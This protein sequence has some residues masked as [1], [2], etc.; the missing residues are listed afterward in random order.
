MRKPGIKSYLTVSVAKESEDGHSPATYVSDLRLIPDLSSS[1][2][3][4]W[5]DPDQTADLNGQRLVA[6][7]LTGLDIVPVSRQPGQVNGI[8]LLELLFAEGIDTGFAFDPSPAASPY[9]ASGT[10]SDDGDTLTVTVGGAHT[11]QRTDDGLILST[12]TDPWVAAQRT[13]VLDQLTG[14]GFGTPTSGEV[15]V[16]TLA[17]TALSDWPRVALI[18]GPA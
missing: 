6:K 18:G 11:L 5:G 2:A 15:S 8:A 17:T 13:S 16:S 7:T 12:L 14:L 4:L 1:T 9:T 3:A 10:V